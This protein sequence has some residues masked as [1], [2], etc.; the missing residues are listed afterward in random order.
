MRQIDE[1]KLRTLTI[2]ADTGGFP[3]QTVTTR[4]VYADKKSVR[5]SEFYAADAAGKR[6]DIVFVINADEWLGETELEH[7]GLI[8][9][10]A[11]SYQV[12]LGRVELTCA[13]M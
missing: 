1:V 3:T 13:R 10:V 7:E 6:V 4:T 5:Q 2:T 12:G 8:Y 9:T 11:R